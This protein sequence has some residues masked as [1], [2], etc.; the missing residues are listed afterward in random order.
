MKNRGSVT[1]LLI[2]VL[3]SSFSS[4]D[5]DDAVNPVS[6]EQENSIY[7]DDE[8]NGV[9]LLPGAGTQLTLAFRVA[10]FGRISLCAYELSVKTKSSKE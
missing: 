4:C 6:E 2:V 8:G 9:P 10:R 3:F 7:D 1:C 5:K